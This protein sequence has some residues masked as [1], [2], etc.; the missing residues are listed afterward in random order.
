[1]AALKFNERRQGDNESFDSFVTDLK[2]LVKDCGYQEECMVRDAIV[3]HCKHP[4]VHEK[5][6]D[7]ADALTCEKAIEIGRNYETNLSSLKKLASDEDPTVKTLSQEKHPPWNRRQRSNKSKGK[8]EKITEANYVESKHKCGRC[9]YDKAHKK[10][11]AMGQ[12]C[13]HCK[14]MNHFSKLCLSKEVHQL[15]E[16]A[17]SAQETEGD[18]DEEECEDDLLFVYSVKSSCVPEDEQFHEV[19]VVEDTEVRFQLDSGAKANVISLKTYNNLRR[20]PPL[21]KTNT[22]LI[23]F[24][25]HRLKPCGE[26]VLSTK[27]K[28]YIL[29]RRC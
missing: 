2:I 11:P 14:K 17:Y 1:M 21:T 10:C 23:S 6:L 26:V 7:Q 5:C 27:Y 18:S 9:G 24:S 8:T 22:V 19:L 28:L 3:F 4:K 25:K 12:Q 13:R 15:Q 20:R 29:C 16:V